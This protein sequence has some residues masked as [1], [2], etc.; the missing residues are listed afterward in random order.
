MTGE[1]TATIYPGPKGNFVFNASTIW[2]VN[3][4]AA[5]PAYHQG[6]WYGVAPKG[7]DS[8]VQ[9]MTANVMARMTGRL[10]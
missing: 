1:Y 7:P 2:W 3:G 9:R 4:L 5:P 10:A 8:R 6:P